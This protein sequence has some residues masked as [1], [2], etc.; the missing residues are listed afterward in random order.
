MNGLLE[1]AGELALIEQRLE[2][3]RAGEGSLTVIEGPAGIGKSSLIRRA[4]ASARDRGMTVLAAR[5]G[6]L[7]R[8]I[9]FGVVRQLVEREVLGADDEARARL[10]SGPAAPAAAVLGLAE[11]PP[12]PGPG[13]AGNGNLQ[14]G[15]YWLTL[16]L[17]EIAPLLMVVDD[18]HWGDGASM[19]AAAYVARRLE[20]A[21][22]AMLTAVRTDEPGSGARSLQ[23]VFSET[24]AEMIRPAP[25]SAEAVE[26]LAE[27]AFGSAS[28]PSPAVTEA[29]LDA[30]GGNPFFITEI[31]REL[32]ESHS[33]P[34]A[35]E[36]AR[37]VGVDADAVRRALL[38]RLGA[39]GPDS[40]SLARAVAVLG[41]EAE[42]RHAMAVASLDE[43]AAV[44]AA[45][46]LV[47]SGLAEGVRPLSLIH[48]LL[49]SAI[50][51]EMS[52]SAVA[53][54]HRLALQVLSAEGVGDDATVGHALASEPDG[55][56]ETVGLLRR[57]AERALLSGSPE[58]AVSY[59]G[60]AL[61]EPPAPAQRPGLLAE[62]GRA[63]V[64]AGEFAAGTLHLDEALAGLEDQVRRNHV[65]RDRAFAA[66]ASG[67]MLE[68][69]DL[70]AGAL[71]EAGDAQGSLQLES[72]LAVLAW[73]SGTD[74]GI[75]LARHRGIEGRTRAERT[76][77]ALLAQEE[78]ATGAPPDEV[79][80][81]ARR[82]LGGGRLIEE[83]TSESLGWYLATHA[84]V[85]CEELDDA[86]RTIDHALADGRRRGSAFGRAG[87]LG[88]RAVLALYE[89]RPRDAE[90]DARA[91]ADGGIPPIMVGINSSFA[92]RAL[93]EQGK[94]EEAASLLG[95]AA[96]GDAPPG[97]AVGKWSR[98]ARAVLD[99]AR[100]DLNA[101]RR[102]I[103]PFR[104]DDE[105]GHSI[106]AFSWRALLA[107][108]LA[109]SGYSEEA[110]RL[111]TE[112]L[113][114][115]EGW[116]RPAALGVARRAW[117]LA[118]PA[119][120]RAERMAVAVD[121]LSRS[122]LRTEEA[123]ARVDLG[124]AILRG[125]SRKAA[126]KELEAGLELALACDARPVAEAAA[127]ELEIAGASP[128]RL[129]FDELTAAERRVAMLATGG[130]TNREIADELFV[131]PKT[132][133]NHLTRIYAKLG[134]SS[135]GDL[136]GVL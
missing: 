125:G 105:A 55:N 46:R 28:A 90:A 23:P 45:D 70:V 30:S 8:E 47:V 53:V 20:G 56:P 78:Q 96:A 14:H 131:T 40:R 57:T 74:A 86:S 79:V 24:G 132:V 31:V 106:K 94:L 95:D 6:V 113:A 77:L 3:A 41:G 17:A 37:I 115:A 26:R 71:A 43:Q 27:R 39:L 66:F 10:L 117:A 92:V 67:G 89:G 9:E 101:V 130:R 32:A 97:P 120:A 36:P 114:W 84:L 49:R 25:L 73:L 98:W 99:E 134:V 110:E 44:D 108:T 109:R 93:V 87:A 15:L 64:R 121:D 60:R 1:R 4:V 83:D 5:G 80:E 129:R 102:D 18:A 34:A 11:M 22:I 122:S 63:E 62:L 133:E 127:T 7:E 118:G 38:M 81:L 124:I 48:P 88:V 104:R 54:A 128:K 119:D 123:R 75:D 126:R 82:A 58:T 103:T 2:R 42:L 68:A 135:R 12:D 116:G 111:A 100:G 61:A 19:L 59:L 50:L 136:A 112:H 91:S 76:I 13:R 16:N 65:W 85:T 33:D 51:K 21:P 107:R 69:R 52:P 72:D 29:I 35:V